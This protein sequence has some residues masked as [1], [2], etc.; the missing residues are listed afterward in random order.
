MKISHGIIVG[1][2]FLQKRV[3]R[4]FVVSDVAQVIRAIESVV[5]SLSP[6]KREKKRKYFAQIAKQNYLPSKGGEGAPPANEAIAN[7][8]VK[9]FNAWAESFEMPEGDSAVALR[10]SGSLGKVATSKMEDFDEVPIRNTSKGMISRFFGTLLGNSMQMANAAETGVSDPVH[11]QH[12]EELLRAAEQFEQNQTEQTH[13]WT[14]RLADGNDVSFSQALDDF[15]ASAVELDAFQRMRQARH[16]NNT[17]TFKLDSNFSLQNTNNSFPNNIDFTPLQPG[18]TSQM[19]TQQY[20][21]HSQVFGGFDANNNPSIFHRS[22]QNQN[23]RFRLLP[24]RAGTAYSIISASSRYNGYSPTFPADS[25]HGHQCMATPGTS[26]GI[27]QLNSPP[28]STQTDYYHYHPYRRD[29][30]NLN[31]YQDPTVGS[32]G[33]S[34]SSSRRFPRQFM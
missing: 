29:D 16:S 12:D 10:F 2:P 26:G 23:A 6:E 20:H 30:G 8:V 15:G 17:H 19:P 28:V 31:R 9:A 18:Q 14:E 24:S 11:D 21:N 1:R 33:G 34:R 22:F 13:K 25:V 32:F 7:H 3:T 27:R 4:T 5:H